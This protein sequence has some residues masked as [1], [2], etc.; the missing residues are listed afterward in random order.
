MISLNK[1]GGQGLGF[2]S[3]ILLTGPWKNVQVFSKYLN[4]FPVMD[5]V[6]L[7]LFL[8]GWGAGQRSYVPWKH[9][10]RAANPGMLLGGGGFLS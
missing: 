10:R 2:V 9:V 1:P 7:P 8:P 6:F 3:T 5:T 4:A